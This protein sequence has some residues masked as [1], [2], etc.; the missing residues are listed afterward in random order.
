MNGRVAV[1][2]VRRQGPKGLQKIAKMG[3]VASG[4]PFFY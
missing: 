3:L 2:A 1:T 4:R